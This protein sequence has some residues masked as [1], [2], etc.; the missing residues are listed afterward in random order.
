MPFKPIANDKNYDKK[1]F[2]AH[3]M[4]LVPHLVD[5][6]ECFKLFR[7]N[8]NADLASFKDEAMVAEFI[9]PY[10]LRHFHTL[11]PKAFVRKNLKLLQECFGLSG[12]ETNILYA[13]D[14]FE[15]IGR[16]YDDDKLDYFEFCF[17]LGGVLH[18]NP[19]KIQKLLMADMP[20][21]KF[22]FISS[23][24]RRGEFELEK[25]AERLMIEPFNK[26]EMMKSL[27][28]IYPKSTLERADFSYMQKDLDM[29]LSF[30]KN[31]KNPSIFLYGKAGVGKNEIAALIA[32]ELDKELW[33]IYN[34]NE[35]GEIEDDRLEQFIRAQA[36]LNADK[37][38]ILLDECEEFF[39][40]LNAK[41]NED[42]ASKN[43]LNKML[44]SVKMP[45]IFLSNSA[46]IDPAF[47]RRFGIVLEIHAP[48]KEKKQA[49][50]EKS[51]KSQGIRLDSMIISQISESCL[52]QGVLLQA[53]KVAKT[54][55]KHKSTQSP[56]ERQKHIK[57]SFIQVLNE[58]LKLQGQKLISINVKKE[59]NL[60]YDM[61]LINASVDMKA[62]CERIKNVCGI[63]DSLSQDSTPLQQGI[64]ILAYGM[65]GS[66]K[67]EFAKALAKEL[68]KPIMLKKASDLLSMW[69]GKSEQNIAK[70]FS[71]AEQK[72]AILVLDEVDSFLQ[73]RSGASRSWEI[74]QVNEMLT[75]M[76]SFAGIFIAT[77]NFMDNLDRAS[78]RRFDMKVEFK[79][80]DSTRLIKAF[81]LYA[82]HLGI[83]DYVEFLE[84]SFAIRALEKLDNIC[85]GDFA[86][87]ARSA[88]FTPL[89]SSQQLL[90]KLQEESKLK[91]THTNTRKMGF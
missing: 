42:K 49:M 83:N 7:K 24:Y 17:L 6:D 9:T 78:I 28:R 62:L 39:P 44:E 54:L 36:M 26:Q 61:S 18:T 84:S 76:E 20:L 41:Y 81:G 13:V 5:F 86:L 10:L 21:R 80:L 37:S 64:R 63:K 90:E 74:T 48:P 52:S 88:N 82:R 55:A 1:L 19:K 73:D 79:P 16:Y 31:A 91:D 66:G 65:A 27:A 67:S 38:V 3:L 89:T 58:H 45:S 72:G 69:L 87:I 46:D 32:K 34:I 50:I 68:D 70:A 25:F 11:K 2:V 75:Q 29:L 56:K 47:L 71:E 43:T 8:F 4:N 77:T 22:G 33:E 85:F 23:G 30:C 60:P 14:L 35:K 59:Q 12:L 15:K 40:N 57:E 51:L 53:C